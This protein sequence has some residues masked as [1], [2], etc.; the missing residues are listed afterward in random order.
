[1]PDTSLTFKGTPGPLI[2]WRQ[3][4]ELRSGDGL[5]HSIQTD[6]GDVVALV[7]LVDGSPYDLSLW[8][9]APEL[10]ESLQEVVRALE[11]EAS[12]DG[13]GNNCWVPGGSMLR[14]ARA[15]ISKALGAE[16]DR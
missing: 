13:R 12:A 7:A 10:L 9:A 4:A 11:L 15:A 6:G 16:T 8:A 14:N 3:P 1:M 2:V 5:D